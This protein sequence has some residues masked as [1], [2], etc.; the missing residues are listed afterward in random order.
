[1]GSRSFHCRW[2]EILELCILGSRTTLTTYQTSLYIYIKH[3]TFQAIFLKALLL[4]QTE[5]L[6]DR[7]HYLTNHIVIKTWVKIV[8]SVLHHHKWISNMRFTCLLYTPWHIFYTS[9]CKISLKHMTHNLKNV[10]NDI[11][12]HTIHTIFLS[13]YI[14]DAII[15]CSLVRQLLIAFRGEMIS[16]NILFTT[17]THTIPITVNVTHIVGYKYRDILL[18]GNLKFTLH[19]CLLA[20]NNMVSIKLQTYVIFKFWI[21]KL[22]PVVCHTK[23]ALRKSN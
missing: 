13:P 3:F 8:L 23:N 9:L 16:L 18:N 20:H 7:I 15:K 10:I 2:M 19:Y 21:A 22:H 11:L 4:M 17:V 5:Q 1:M 6:C 14:L 12:L